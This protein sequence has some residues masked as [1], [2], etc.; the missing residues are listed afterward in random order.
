[1]GVKIE[2]WESMQEYSIKKAIKRE[3]TGN[4]Q[5]IGNQL[6]INW[7]STGRQQEIIKES[8]GNQLGNGKESTGNRQGIKL[9]STGQ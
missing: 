7:E 3:S 6:G 5:G 8:I 1:M 4:R 2:M 9:T